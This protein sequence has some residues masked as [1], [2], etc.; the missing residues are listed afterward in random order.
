ME[1]RPGLRGRRRRAAH[2]QIVGPQYFETL[3]IP[4]LAGRPFG[5]SD[6]GPARPVAIVNEEFV[7]K[8]LSGKPAV[9]R[10]V[11]V[12]SM[13]MNGPGWVDREIVSVSGQVAVDG[14]A[15]SEKSAEIYV[16]L[17]QNPWFDAS[18]A[19]RTSGDQVAM[20]AAIRSAIGK[21]DRQLAVTGVRTMEDIAYRSAA[22]PRFR[23]R[24][25]GG[26]AVLALALAAVGVFGVLAFS[27]AQQTREFGIR[28]A[29]GAH[30]SDVLSKV[31]LR[32]VWI[33]VVGIAVGTAGALVV[34]RS[35]SSLLYGVAPVDGVTF[36]ASAAVL[37]LVALAAALVPAVR[38]ARVD[39]AVVLRGL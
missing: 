25:L 17:A 4:L 32:G 1:H 6:R 39:P 21:A 37:A 36:G 26:F 3:G 18:L 35:L 30:T 38:A 8:Y 34:T 22:R 9:G 14:L 19:V 7:R 23:A 2:Y 16:P 31:L 11:R 28:I 5:D 20:T 12:Q 13:G 33:A 24:L 29:L 27:V 15:E 10:H